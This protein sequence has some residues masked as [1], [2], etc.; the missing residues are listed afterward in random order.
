MFEPEKTI[1]D[2]LAGERVAQ[3]QEAREAG[4]AGAFDE[5][6][7]GAVREAHGFRELGLG[8][9]HEAGEPFAE[10]LERERVGVARRE[11][12]REGGGGRLRERPARV[13]GVVDRGGAFGLHA[14]D[15]EP[16]PQGARDGEPADGLR[17]AADRVDERV[18]LGR[19]LQHLERERAGAGHH[20]GVVR[21]VHHVQ[22]RLAHEALRGRRAT[23]RS[24]GL[25]RRA[26]RRARA[27]P[28]SSRGCCRRERTP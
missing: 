21:R 2:G 15:R 19:L 17:A 23:R 8:H 25:P 1:A 13:P 20:G 4:G 26:G 24:R 9:R 22:A 3:L 18:D 10:R 11:A 6:V 16:G 27:W 14:V 12:V 5:R 28:R 7:R